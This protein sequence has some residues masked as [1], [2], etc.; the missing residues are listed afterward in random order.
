MNYKNDIK[1][2]IEE[3]MDV[4]RHLLSECIDDI[5]KAAEMLIDA[6]RENKKIYLCG[7]G[8]SAS[9]CQ[10][11]ACELV[12]KLR[13]KSISVPAFSLVTN[14]S[15]LTALANDFGYENIFSKQLAVYAHAGDILIA[16]STSGKSLNVIKAAEFAKKH[17]IKIVVMTGKKETPL[18]RM[19]D[20]AIMVPSD[21]T[22]RIQES[23]ILIGHILALIIEK[24]VNR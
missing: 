2:E 12:G 23:H 13:K 4:K 14:I 11:I 19:A 21:D 6:L 18:S 7:N 20:L 10:H 9:D 3:S 8:G 1:R 24:V 16:L 22:P 5:N 17:N 15:A